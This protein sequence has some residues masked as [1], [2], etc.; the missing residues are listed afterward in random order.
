VYN[1][2]EFH[3]TEMLCLI[4]IELINKVRYIHYNSNGCFIEWV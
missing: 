1:D 2:D 3:F 4:T